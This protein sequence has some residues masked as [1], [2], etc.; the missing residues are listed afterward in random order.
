VVVSGSIYL[1]DHRTSL[2][3]EHK[4]VNFSTSILITFDFAH[5]SHRRKAIPSYSHACMRV[6]HVIEQLYVEE[7]SLNR[8]RIRIVT[9]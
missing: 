3:V 2:E 9:T 1:P 4:T 5:E 6:T 7:P 8:C